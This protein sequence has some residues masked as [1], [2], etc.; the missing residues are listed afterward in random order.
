LTRPE[1]DVAGRFADEVIR[2]IRNEHADE[3]AAVIETALADE[4]PRVYHLD[5][6][7]RYYAL[8]ERAWLRWTRLALDY[9]TTH[10]LQQA[11]V[12]DFNPRRVRNAQQAG[13]AEAR[14]GLHWRLVDVA[15]DGGDD[16][17]WTWRIEAARQVHA[18]TR[19]VLRVGA[20]IDPLD[21]PSVYELYAGIACAA[22]ALAAAIAAGFVEDAAGEVRE[23][24]QAMSRGAG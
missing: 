7:T 21:P 17:E 20:S 24:V 23:T 15:A 1:P 18:S 3:T 4:P 2:A 9:I 22:D 14:C 13:E 19:K 8:C 16:P 6:V 12:G 5:E 10:R 11:S